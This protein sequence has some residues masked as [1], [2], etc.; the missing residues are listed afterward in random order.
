ML[1]GEEL[2]AQRAE[3]PTEVGE[4]EKVIEE[5]PHQGLTLERIARMQVVE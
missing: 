3:A 2:L 5:V 1:L 4:D